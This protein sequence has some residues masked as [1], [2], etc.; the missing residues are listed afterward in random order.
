MCMCVGRFISDSHLQECLMPIDTG[1]QSHI[2]KG[3][4]VQSRQR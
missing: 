4:R 1:Y 3:L 2:Y